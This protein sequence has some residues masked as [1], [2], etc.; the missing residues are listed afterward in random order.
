LAVP[1]IAIIG[2][3]ASAIG[4]LN[5][6][7]SLAVDAEIT[8]FSSDKYFGFSPNHRSAVADS[9]HFYTHIYENIKSSAAHYPPRKTF[10][11]DTVPCYVVN[12]DERFFK[13]DMFGGQTN[14]WGGFVL[15]A[16]PLRG[17]SLNRIIKQSQT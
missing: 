15:P 11:G 17:R 2:S 8:L 9:E 5:G 14:I 3:G 13:S 12:G 7:Q 10:Y 4:V 6:L 1:K 16:G